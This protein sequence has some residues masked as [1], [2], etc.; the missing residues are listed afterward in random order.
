MDFV[1]LANQVILA[2]TPL[3]PFISGVSVDVGTGIVTKL[4]EDVYDQ[5][6]EQVKHLYQTVKVRVEE[7]KVTDGGKASKAL[8]NFVADPDDY[9]DVFRRKLESLLKADP[10]FAKALDQMLQE[11][12][13]LRQVILLGENAIAENNE[14][15]NTFGIGEQHL[16]LGDGSKAIGNRQSISKSS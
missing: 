1:T 16:E 10:S 5:S 3:L 14:Q 15:I 8:Q 7:E 11:N 2:L 4:G 12:S 13:A 6:K 9:T